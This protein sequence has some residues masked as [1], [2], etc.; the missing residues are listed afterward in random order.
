MTTRSMLFVGLEPRSTLV[1]CENIQL[2]CGNT[3]LRIH[4]NPAIASNAQSMSPMI[5]AVQKESRSSSD[6]IC[7]TDLFQTIFL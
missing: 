5:K 7:I 2:S 6:R 1:S 3:V 4:C